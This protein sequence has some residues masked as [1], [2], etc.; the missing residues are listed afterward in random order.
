M[1][2]AKKQFPDV[3][4]VARRAHVGIMRGMARQASLS[5]A[6]KKKRSLNFRSCGIHIESSPPAVRNDKADE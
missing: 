2:I 1:Y 5:K 4:T 6:K 3:T